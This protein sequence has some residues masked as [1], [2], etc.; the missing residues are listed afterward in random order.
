[1]AL[2]DDVLAAS[3]DWLNHLGHRVSLDVADVVVVETVGTVHLELGH[4]ASGLAEG[5]TTPAVVLTS[6]T[7]GLVTD[8]AVPAISDGDAESGSSLDV[9]LGVAA[10]STASRIV[11]NSLTD[12]PTTSVVEGNGVRCESAR[13][14]ER[15][16]GGKNTGDREHCD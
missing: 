10:V 2:A 16:S 9:E 5:N 4:T 14:N 8:T 7:R 15:D 1:L 11:A 12:V 6:R 13:G 3:T